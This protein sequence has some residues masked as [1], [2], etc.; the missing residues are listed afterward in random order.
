[1]ELPGTDNFT[2]RL[3]SSYMLPRHSKIVPLQLSSVDLLIAQ[4]TFVD[5][6]RH[7]APP[8]VLLADITPVPSLLTQTDL[9]ELGFYPQVFQDPDGHIAAIFVGLPAQC[10]DWERTTGHANTIMRIA[11]S[12]LDSGCLPGDGDGIKSGIAYDTGL[13]HPRTIS[14]A[15]SHSLH[16]LVV[17]AALR[18]SPAIQDITLF[19]NAVLKQVAPCVWCDARRVIDVVVQND[20]DLHLL[21]KLSEEPFYQ[22]TAL[23]ELEYCFSMRDSTAQME[24]DHLAGLRA[25]TS[26]G[27]YPYH[28]G[29]M[30]LWNHRVVVDFPPGST[31]FFPAAVMPYLFTNVEKPGWQ[32]LIT[33]ACSAGLHR[34]VANGFTDQHVPEP[35]FPMQRAA[36]VHRLELAKDTVSL[37]PTVTEYDAAEAEIC[38]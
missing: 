2:V 10:Q 9:D 28:E 22:P 26:I 17:L 21:L 1:M 31:M 18:Y 16:N 33:Q 30:I 3:W 12:E 20:Y 7:T 6:L 36:A 37:Y 32:M 15:E 11:R 24:G 19:Q 27:Q 5:R 13:K 25:L 14:L 8:H 35:R 38:Y 4:Y 34:Y 23:S 29:K